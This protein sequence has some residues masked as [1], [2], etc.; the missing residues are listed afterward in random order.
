[1]LT[2]FNLGPTWE[3]KHERAHEVCEHLAASWCGT[4]TEFVERVYNALRWD[5]GVTRGDVRMVLRTSPSVSFKM[6]IHEDGTR[7]EFAQVWRG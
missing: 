1:M 6:V 2:E 3:P 7:E 4:Q 5:W